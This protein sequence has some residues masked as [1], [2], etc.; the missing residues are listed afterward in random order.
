M[1]VPAGSGVSRLFP[2]AVLTVANS[3]FTEATIGGW[4]GDM[5]EIVAGIV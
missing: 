1:S 2:G 5:V 3:L 4:S